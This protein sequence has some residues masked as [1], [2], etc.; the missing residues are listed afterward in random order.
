MKTGYIPKDKR[1][2]ILFLSDDMRV[3]SGIGVMS[4]EIVE[5]TAHYF[6]WVQVGAGVNHP[7]AGKVLDLSDAM[8][9]ET[10]I[11]DP[12]VRIYP[13]NGYGD[14]R[15]IRQLIE[16]EQPDAILHFTDPRYWIWLYQMEHEIRQKMPIMYYNIWDDL[17]FPMYNKEYYMSCDSLFSISKQTYN[18]NKHVLGPKNPRHLAYIPHGIN[19]NRY[20]PLPADDANV[21][22]TRKKLFGDAQVDYVIFYNS[23]NI[24]RKQTS[25]IIYAFK[26]FM[27][28]L[29]PE[30]RER[31]RLVMHTQPV[32][33]NGTDLP[34]VI[35][36]VTP[37]VEKYIIFSADRV[38]A[39]FLNHLYN[40]ADV[41]INMSSN[42][43]F[44]LGTCESMVAGTPIIVNVTGGLQDQCGFM[45]EE[46]N[47]L[48]PDKHFT[49]EWGS[50]HD[51]R[52]K[53]YGEWAFPMFPTNRS[54][55]GSP[56]TPYIFDDRASFEDAADRMMEVYGLSREERKRRGELGRQYALGHGKFTT[57]H[58]CN[59]FI[60]H[61]NKGFT[62]W[63]PRKRFTLEQV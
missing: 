24:R 12:Y 18:I 34:A 41:S 6:N 13:Y 37:E 19:T 30:Q 26:V 53:K 44:G 25:D 20:H 21:L 50:N 28:K 3:T 45:D 7:E 8:K 35:R 61:I 46:G 36:D 43:G 38:E 23:R 47:Y 51:G 4:R 9:K 58:M 15:L 57:E 5:G 27:M 2:K 54:I 49:Y 59:S 56:M 29:T 22:E 40:I 31:V 39:G 55:Q 10:G 14:S 17:P 16:I 11:D 42:E 62:N 52:Y 33:D 48:D 1:K 63:T 60:E 32:D